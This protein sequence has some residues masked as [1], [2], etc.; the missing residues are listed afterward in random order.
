MINSKGNREEKKRETAR[1]SNN[2]LLQYCS[3]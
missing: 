3:K 1:D 2:V